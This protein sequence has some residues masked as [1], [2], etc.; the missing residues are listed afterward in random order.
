[1]AQSESSSDHRHFLLVLVGPLCPHGVLGYCF[2]QEII[3]PSICVLA[4]NSWLESPASW[5]S[6]EGVGHTCEVLLLSY[7]SFLQLIYLLS[8]LIICCF[9]CLRIKTCLT[10]DSSSLLL[11]SSHFCSIS[12]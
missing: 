6:S 9:S 5:C 10:V 1:M 4:C 3:H 7:M 11:N 12:Y 2:L 8:L